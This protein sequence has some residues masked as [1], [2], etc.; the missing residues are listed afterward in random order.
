MKEIKISITIETI[1][2]IFLAGIVFWLLY[3]FSNLLLI[4]L[5]AII[6]STSFEPLVKILQ[7]YNIPR[8]LSVSVV[9]LSII[10]LITGSILIFIPLTIEQLGTFTSNI[11]EYT[12][13][14][15]S[16][17]LEKT[18][19]STSLLGKLLTEWNI[20]S[21]SLKEIF[22]FSSDTLKK[23]FSSLTS[24]LSDFMLIMV[25]SFYFAAQEHGMQIF[26]KKIV[27]RKYRNY[28]I[29]LWERAQKKITLWIQGQ[30]ILGLIIGVMVY[31]GLA[32]LGIP[33]AGILAIL[34]GFFEL[35]P[36]VGQIIAAVP[37]VIL[38][39]IHGDATLAL[40]V[41]AMYTVIQFTEGQIIAPLVVNKLVGVPTIIVILSLIVGA[42]LFGFLGVIIAI[43]IAAVVVELVNDTEKL[44]E[45]NLKSGKIDEVDLRVKK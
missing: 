44:Q 23:T 6:L 22:S 9:Y 25:L 37:S 21:S 14:I 7:K 13:K 34:A 20:N 32:S 4:I 39:F 38:G 41:I 19:D 15:D 18:A 40:M 3:T 29:S 35:I 5:T 26:L 2:K 12:D 28:S 36:V 10:A 11:S 30:F 42:Q 31:I 33:Q 8:V 45:K 17:I 43:P 16:Y 27:P 24:G 1:L